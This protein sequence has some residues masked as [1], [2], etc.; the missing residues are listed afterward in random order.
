M[1]LYYL[2]RNS[3]AGAFGLGPHYTVTVMQHKAERGLKQVRHS[4]VCAASR[5]SVWMMMCPFACISCV[6]V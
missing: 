5:G 4:A 6:H 1:L 2:A 3:L